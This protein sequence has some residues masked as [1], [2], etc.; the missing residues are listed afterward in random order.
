MLRTHNMASIDINDLPAVR[1]AVAQANE[2]GHHVRILAIY[3]DHLPTC[4]AR[5]ALANGDGLASNLVCDCGWV[6]AF[7]APMHQSGD[8]AITSTG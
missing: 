1:E 3:G 6:D 4:E 7:G 8:G 2:I 5:V